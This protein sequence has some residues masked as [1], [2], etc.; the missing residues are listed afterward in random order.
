MIDVTNCANI[1]VRFV[2]LEDRGIRSDE[3]LFSFGGF[4]GALERTRLWY[5]QSARSAKEG[6][7]E[8]HDDFVYDTPTLTKGS[9]WDE[10][11]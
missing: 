11:E 3:L 4:Q 7:S 5:A 2:A 8:R 6:P 9:E 10:M 1:D